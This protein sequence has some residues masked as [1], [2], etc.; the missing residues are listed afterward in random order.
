MSLVKGVFLPQDKV[1]NCGKE[2]QSFD[3]I[4]KEILH[5]G[6][7]IAFFQMF[8]PFPFVME[9]LYSGINTRMWPLN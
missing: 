7:D 9:L 1:K 8:A 5:S 6:F 4:L 3:V 2:N